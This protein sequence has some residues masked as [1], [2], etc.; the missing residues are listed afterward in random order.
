MQSDEGALDIPST[1][2]G[3]T[4]TGNTTTSGVIAPA[5]S[6][7]VSVPRRS[8]RLRHRPERY[9]DGHLGQV[10]LKEGAV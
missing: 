4:T 9:G 6:D 10:T 8:S 5:P 2:S 3:A 1:E 7:G